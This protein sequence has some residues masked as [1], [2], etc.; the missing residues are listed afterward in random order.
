MHNVVEKRYNTAMNKI[1]WIGTVAGIIGA[2]VVALHFFLIGYVFF[3]INSASWLYVGIRKNDK[4]LILMN[5]VYLIANLI[6]LY[7]A[8]L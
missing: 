7:N 6:G 1:S 3:L 5:S 8:I 2:F 4:P